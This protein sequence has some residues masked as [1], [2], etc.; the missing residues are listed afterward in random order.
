MRST[1]RHELQTNELADVIGQMIAQAKPHA[2]LIGYSAAVAIL[3]V[4][5]FLVVPALRGT[6]GVSDVA[7]A[8]FATAMA[9]ATDGPLKDFLRDFPDAK[10]V[11]AVMIE[12]A[13]RL[14]MESVRRTDNADKAITEAEADAKLAEAKTLYTQ[15]V[16]TSKTDEPLARAKL[17]LVAVEEGDINKGKAA[18]EEVAKKWPDSE[19]AVLARLHLDR[20]K[21][22]Q[23]IE[24]SDE[25]LESEKKGEEQ[26][27]TS[28]KA[29]PAART[30]A[31]PENPPAGKQPAAAGS[32]QGGAAN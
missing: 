7:A 13:D 20:L 32:K 24:F 19:A 31:Q 23:P 4:V 18:L 11:P 10:Q 14:F 1:R 12:L 27:G 21:N 16:A 28:G 17:G 30:N 3:L 6:A 8:S 2:R 22:Y 15:A 29:P 26:G 9:S 5:V 25:P